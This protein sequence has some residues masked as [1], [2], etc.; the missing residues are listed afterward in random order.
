MKIVSNFN[1][2]QT[3]S[4]W[5]NENCCE[6]YLMVQTRQSWVINSSSTFF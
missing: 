4:E 6:E 2:Q 5:K 1:Q 3:I